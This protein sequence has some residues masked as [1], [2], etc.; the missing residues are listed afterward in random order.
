M[1]EF[2][3]ERF[4]Y[5][6]RGDWSADT[7]Y[8]RDDI[9]RVGGKSYVCVVTHISNSSF[10]TDLN[11][12]LPGSIPPQPQPKW[13][14]MTSASTFQGDWAQSIDYNLGDV[15][16]YNGSL[17]SCTVSHSSADFAVDI[18]NWT[19]FA[20]TSSFI[21][22]WTTGVSYAP[23][24]VVKY[25][26]NMHKCIT[27]H[28]SQSLLEDNENDWVLY[29]E[30]VEVQN[31]WQPST[32]YRVNDLVKYGGT[33]F[34]CIETHTSNTTNLD[35]TKFT[36]EV[37]GSQ[38]DGTWDA[39]L[40][41]NIGDIVRHSGF[42]YYA[43]RNNQNSKPYTDNDSSD[44]ILLARS[45][46]F[47]GDWSIDTDYKT[48][49]VVLRGGNLYIAVRDIS[50]SDGVDGSTLDYLEDDTWE[51]LL[52]GKSFKGNWT[53]GET[54]SLN[55]IVYFKG[56][57]YS[58][59]FEHE[60]AMSNFP[61]DNGSGYY[62]WDTL[63]QSGQEAALR[64][65]G[66]ILTY[67]PSR[68]IDAD[69]STVFDDS[70]LGDARVPIG[71]SEQILSVTDDLEVF[72]RNITE[73]AESVFV[74]TNGI[75]AEGRGTFQN[76]F[77]TV[78]YAAE[79]VEDTYEPLTPVTIRLSGG[80]YEE[81]GPIIVPAGCAVN[82]DELRSTTVV[83]TPPIPEYQIDA[84]ND[85]VSTINTRLGQII[86]DM[87]TG[88]VITPTDGNTE[89]Q[90]TEDLVAVVDAQGNPVIDSDT[91]LPL[92]ENRFPISD[93]DG[94]QR[95]AELLDDYKN[96]IEFATAS[97]QNPPTITGSNVLES[98]ENISN[99]GK[100]LYLNRKFIKAELIAYLKAE[101]GEDAV[102]GEDRIKN[103]IQSLIRGIKRDTTYSGN[104][105]T[106]FAGR[107]YSNALVGSQLD[108]LFFLR[109]TTGLRDLTTGGLKGTLNPPGVFELYQKPTGGACVSLDPGWGPDDER[110]WI[111][112]RSPYIQGV[113][114]IGTG[115][116]GKRVDG[117]LH[118]GG[119]KS[120]VS[121]DFTQVLS[122]GIGVWVSD[123][124]RTELVS[125]FTY[126]CQIGYFAEDGGII[127]ATNGNNSYGK[128]GSIA[129]GVDDTETPQ[130][131]TLFNRNN[132]ALIKEAFAGGANDE[133]K[134]F[135]YENC[136]EEYTQAT[137]T[138]VGSGSNASVEFTDFRNGALFEARLTSGDGSSTPGGTGYLLR[139]GN[140]QETI[141]ASSTIKLAAV[142]PTQ[143]ASEIQGMRLIITDGTGVGQ[144]G[145]V[146][147]FDFAS[148]VVT[149]RRDSD[150]QLGWD[151]IIPGT[152]LVAD[153]DLTTR[154]VI[155]PRVMVSEPNSAI[156]EY[157]L[158]TNRTYV[159]LAYGDTT[160]TFNNVFGGSSY[161]W[162][163]SVENYVT[164]SEIVSPTAIQFNAQFVE[165]LPLTPFAIK[166]RTSE[167][168]ATV[169]NISANTGEVI[170]VD[171]DG[172]GD[173]FV[174]GE[175]I[176]IVLESGS[177][178]AFDEESVPARFNV[179]REGKSYS[180]QLVSG[181][182]GYAA[183]DK[184]KIL[185]T[186]LGGATPD[187]DLTITVNTASDDS[188][189]SVL[190]FSSSGKGKKGR[191]IALTDS[192]FVRYS[193]NGVNFSEV[194][195][196]FTASNS[197]KKLIA[198]NNR[199]I[200]VAENQGRVASSLDGSTWTEVALPITNAWQDG[201]YG[202]GK[203]VIVG[204]DTDL[205]LVSSDGETWTTSS[206]P[207]DTVGD[208]TIAQWSNVV[209]GKGKYVAISY[210]DRATATSTDTSTWTRHDQALPAFSGNITSATYGKNM[211]V[212]VTDA[213][214]SA[215]SFDGETWY[216][217]GTIPNSV[218]CTVVKYA[219]GVFFTLGQT[220]GGPSLLAA[221]SDDG[222]N[223][224][225]FGLQTAKQWSALCHDNSE[226][227]NKWIIFASAATTNAINHVYVGTRA[228]IRAEVLTGQIRTL[229]IL[230]PGSN[231]DADNL[232]VITI[233]DP[234][235]DTQATYESRI[236]NRVLSQP[237]FIN[238]GSGYRRS[239]SSI[240]ISGDG[241]ADIIPEENTI[242]VAG[243]RNIPNPGVQIKIEG[244]EDPNASVPGTLFVFS[245]VEVVDLGDDGT[246][247][248]TRL[249]KFTISP[250]VEPE[251]N[252]RHATNITLR[253]RFSQCRISG[254]DF[255]DIGTGNFE[256][257]NYPELYAGGAYFVSA[258]ENEVYEANSGRIF[259]V[260]TDQDG[261]FR[262]GELFS[263]Q[264][265]TGIVTISAQFFDLDGLSELALGGVR[266]GGTGTVVNE[267]ST[268]PT[269]AAD[270]NNVIPTQRA[271]A[272]FLADR[273]SVGGENLEVNKLQAGR[274]V[275][276]GEQTEISNVAGRNIVIPPNVIFNGSYTTD[277]G[278]GNIG[279]AQVGISGT[280][281]TQFLLMKTNDESMQ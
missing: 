169:I 102:V 256:Q 212:V 180:V 178:E 161:I 140:A 86:L 83:A 97:G 194:A 177:G 210:N 109:D 233:T 149:V 132:E 34:R 114:N 174:E 244:V 224:D 74:A 44:W 55:D 247:N 115:C 23:G 159:D 6:W 272:T 106:V 121:N 175:E 33:I 200:A 146:D 265:A 107:R 217:G 45:V 241:Y 78:R 227:G 202:D 257:T 72:W 12:I 249:I 111:K 197:Y 81:I 209:Y 252:L 13:T 62:F 22:N 250:S 269:F 137:A 261:N 189:N 110:V 218:E 193:D 198:G 171:L 92:L 25:N 76:P 108:S 119:L 95:I 240:I 67:G 221:K 60:A 237:D 136:G 236:G 87:I 133:L 36:E 222:I 196:P 17:W 98:S 207:D 276:G 157:D 99:A 219:Q 118:N 192:E 163:D 54:Y 213:S 11:A 35:D 229:K 190:T 277:D 234:N 215:Y 101:L 260:S 93:A 191:Y 57:A 113:T 274:V 89:T 187:N 71:E 158:F 5:N 151:H 231:Y 100:A 84:D 155:E 143:L 103:D 248:N 230:D 199:F 173:N 208:S 124:A 142:D 214:E 167:A 112:N 195:L 262:T 138:V 42:M 117:S 127:R 238:R 152:P 205:V 53:V 270:S 145:Y 2:K 181:G 47:A 235:A 61:G 268:D 185:G 184:I 243:V 183:E 263:V 51:L 123:N 50:A 126:Y 279:T 29:F 160:E 245:G 254:H 220:A 281:I 26:G 223:W 70:T 120:M 66:D 266:L 134:I 141:G 206:I 56:S 94:A 154:Y 186:Q 14:V 280:I 73:D 170:E 3:L 130:S 28:I 162:Q 246:E 24:A 278:E 32:Q 69:G 129:D 131:A 85:V 4:K 156:T 59:N 128:Y 144:Y 27:A 253:E 79:Y 64:I 153:L 259:Y 232:P 179:T 30:G 251:L 216:A 122:D 10:R 16:L 38:F 147:D 201:T 90:L 182:S 49:D 204:N 75:D 31:D 40:Y 188:T 19:I 46:S 166:G 273:L 275:I 9:V 242:T 264:Q 68:E 211:F 80:K 41:Y 168:E 65:K 226:D 116:V 172:N 39:N 58:C 15:V 1:A 21:G 239:T 96:Y 135:E 104:Y 82:G 271:I 48:G 18:N 125:V 139:Q 8:K 105:A 255:L 43:I 203:F 88:V 20:Q 7:S 148:K 176:S 91:G 164:V 258:P 165:V 37:F 52:P 63:I 225:Q 228:K 267:F 150:D 77:R